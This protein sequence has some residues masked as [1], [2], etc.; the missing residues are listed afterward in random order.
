M[1]PEL[2]WLAAVAVA[3][4]L[5]WLPYVL[6]ILMEMGVVAALVGRAGD[7]PGS[8]AWAKRSQ[9]AHLNAIENLAI[10]APLALAVHVAGVGSETTALAAMAY[11][12]VRV[13]HYA[14]YVAGIPIIRTLLFAAGVICQLALGAALLGAI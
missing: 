13:A 3:T 1:S 6:N 5:M 11:F 12:W 9:R 2:Y 8:A 10:F 4:A 14:V 7:D